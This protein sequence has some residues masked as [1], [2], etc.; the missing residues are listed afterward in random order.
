MARMSSCRDQELL[1]QLLVRCL[2][3]HSSCVLLSRRSMQEIHE[4]RDRKAK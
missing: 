3:G 4:R 2:C 1:R